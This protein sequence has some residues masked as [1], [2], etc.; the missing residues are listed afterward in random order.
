MLIL[1][2]LISL[3]K[4]YKFGIAHRDLKPSNI[5]LYEDEKVYPWKITDFEIAEKFENYIGKLILVKEK[6]NFQF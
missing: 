5:L 3:I 2:L 1:T 6:R 4:L